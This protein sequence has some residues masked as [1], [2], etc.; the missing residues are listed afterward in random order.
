MR[1]SRSV[2]VYE[3]TTCPCLPHFLFLGV[4]IKMAACH[5]QPVTHGPDC[6]V[7]YVQPASLLSITAVVFLDDCCYSMSI[8]QFNNIFRDCLWKGRSRRTSC[9][10]YKQPSEFKNITTMVFFRMTSGYV[11]ICVANSNL[12]EISR[13]GSATT[14]IKRKSH[15]E[16]AG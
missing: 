1:P 6:W 2:P 9:Y 3:A 4:C 8:Q 14:I 16:G 7:Q 10:S 5:S 15:L 12:S 11:Q 13:F